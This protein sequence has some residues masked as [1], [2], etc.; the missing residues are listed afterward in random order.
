MHGSF[1]KVD[2]VRLTGNRTCT[3]SAA[4]HCCD[5]CSLPTTGRE[6][7]LPE[8][9]SDRLFEEQRPLPVREEM[10][11][12]VVSMPKPLIWYSH[13]VRFHLIRLLQN[14][15][16]YTLCLCPMPLPVSLAPNKPWFNLA[17]AIRLRCLSRM[18]APYPVPP[19]PM[20]AALSPTIYGHCV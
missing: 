4:R 14:E 8:T 18:K 3:A 15:T 13:R 17:T 16:H 6:H 20:T 10:F 19:S 1:A 11:L 2:T 5:L 7:A 9:S 12:C